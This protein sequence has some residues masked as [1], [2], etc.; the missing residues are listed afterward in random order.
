MGDATVVP[1]AAAR[2]KRL[3]VAVGRAADAALLPPL[4]E[5]LRG[6][7]RLR[8]LEPHPGTPLPASDARTVHE[9]VSS[10]GPLR[11]R[12]LTALA[13]FGPDAVLVNGGSPEATATALACDDASVPLVHLG[14]G[15]VGHAVDRTAR[16]R[17][18]L[19]SD[20]ARLHLPATGPDASVLAAEGVPAER[21]AVVGSLLQDALTSGGPL[22]PPERAPS[23]VLL[24]L[25]ADVRR[26]R[27]RRGLR[28][29]VELVRALRECGEPVSFAVPPWL[30]GDEHV[31]ERGYALAAA[32]ATVLHAPTRREFVRLLADCAALATDC[33][34]LHEAA[35]GMGLPALLL[36]PPAAVVRQDAP[37]GCVALG[38]PDLDATL[39]ALGDLAAP[40]RRERG[41]HRVRADGGTGSGG[42]AAA[43]V[44]ELL[45]APEVWRRLR[46]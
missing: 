37:D 7:H 26:S 6:H 1:F 46:P 40:R 8:L 45:R 34:D 31:R 36:P 11:S 35:C 39:A 13:E 41:L 42:S 19:V 17:R 29:A 27:R 12:A 3:L 18:R 38:A 30:P 9:V 44:A 33:E 21:V 5:R 4:V 43:R 25:T 24:C 32:G 23:G 20:A 14:A 15:R 16:V 10:L 28:Q 22:P 2:P